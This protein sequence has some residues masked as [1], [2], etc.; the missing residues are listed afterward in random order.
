MTKD[1]LKI[2]MRLTLSECP[3]RY[4]D[5]PHGNTG[6]VSF[7]GNDCFGLKMEDGMEVLFFLNL[8]WSFAESFKLESAVFSN[9]TEEQ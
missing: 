8:F 6:E 7:I 2:G 9:A 3:D 4:Y 5:L 1:E